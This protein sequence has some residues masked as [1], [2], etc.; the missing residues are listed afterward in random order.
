MALRSLGQDYYL[1]PHELKTMFV[2]GTAHGIGMLQA[3][4]TNQTGYEPMFLHSNVVKWGIRAF[5]CVKCS[6]NPIDGVASSAFENV[7][8]SINLHLKEH[9]RI[10]KIKD[11]ESMGIDPEPLIWRSMEHTACRSVWKDD[12]L[13][14][15][16]RDHMEKTFGNR[17]RIGLVDGLLGYVDRVCIE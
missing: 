12:G 13:C 17:F 4:P 9:S 16:T 6:S 8:S 10:F 14:A 15:R 11:M 7:D 3:D 2:N 5:Y 1:V